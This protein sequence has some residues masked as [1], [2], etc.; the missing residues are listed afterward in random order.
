MDTIT[1]AVLIADGI[2]LAVFLYVFF[3]KKKVKNC[4]HQNTFTYTDYQKTKVTCM[5]CLKTLKTTNN[6][7]M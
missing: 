1:Q 2:G 6:E 4:Q 5:C 3:K 7:T